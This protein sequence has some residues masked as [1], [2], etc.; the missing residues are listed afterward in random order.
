MSCTTSS[1]GLTASRAFRQAIYLPYKANPSN[2]PADRDAGHWHDEHRASPLPPSER[3]KEMTS[4]M[5]RDWQG[6]ARCLYG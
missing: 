4:G 5:V 1:R 2:W 3:T 6:Y